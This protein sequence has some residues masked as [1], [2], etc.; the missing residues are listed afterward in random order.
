MW[1][2]GELTE[3]CHLGE[4]EIKN[5]VNQPFSGAV[6]V[7]DGQILMFAI[8]MFV[9]LSITLKLCTVQCALWELQDSCLNEHE[10]SAA[11]NEYTSE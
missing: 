1:E 6:E 2:E 10:C 3:A 9:C 11:P 4:E 7:V 8:D 5:Q